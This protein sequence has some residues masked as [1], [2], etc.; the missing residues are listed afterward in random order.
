MYVQDKLKEEADTVVQLLIA[1]GA[2]F[3]VCGDIS[4]ANDVSH[5]LHSIL[6]H[7]AAMTDQEARSFVT[8]M[9]ENGTYHEDIF[10]VTLRTAEVTDRFRTAA[11]RNWQVQLSKTSVT[12]GEEVRNT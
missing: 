8:G 4:M 10:G 6:T 9:K 7:N 3:Y 12:I 11:R 5:T 2:H 1:R